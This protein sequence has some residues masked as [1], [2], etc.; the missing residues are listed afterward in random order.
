ML[1]LRC[2]PLSELTWEQ[3][4]RLLSQS[5]GGETKRRNLRSDDLSNLELPPFVRSVFE[6]LAPWGR[7]LSRAWTHLTTRHRGRQGLNH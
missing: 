1:L 5:G 4:R 2:L 6:E 7:V 3:K